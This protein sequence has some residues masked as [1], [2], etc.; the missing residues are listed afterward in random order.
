METSRNN[1]TLLI[2]RDIEWSAIEE[3]YCRV[4][5]FTPFAIVESGKVKASSSTLPY[6]SL[7]VE[8][9]KVFKEASMPVVHKQDFRNLWEV[10]REIDSIDTKNMD[11]IVIHAPLKRRGLAKLFS[12]ILPSLVIQ[13]HGKGFFKRLDNKPGKGNVEAWFESL[14]P[15]AEWDA[16][17]E[18]LK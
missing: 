11:I 1:E 14:K 17:P 12:G 18:G 15:I 16:R 5:H 2:G 13:V 7:L 3:Q 10:F 9:P 6:A 8:C 4:N